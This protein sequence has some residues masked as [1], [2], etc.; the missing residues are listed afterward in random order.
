LMIPEGNKGSIAAYKAIDEVV[1]QVRMFH[2]FVKLN[3][4][5]IWRYIVCVISHPGS[6]RSR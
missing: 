5:Y 3:F 1:T 2:S 4:K 6:G